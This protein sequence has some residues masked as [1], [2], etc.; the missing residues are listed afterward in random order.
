M[1]MNKPKVTLIGQDGNAYYILGSCTKA[2]RKA[3]W[4]REKINKVMKE[5][6]SGDYDHLLRTAGEYF[7]IE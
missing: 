5:M 7:D 6:R 1:Q 4:S 2:A 3:N